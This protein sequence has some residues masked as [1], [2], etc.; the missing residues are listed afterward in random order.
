MREDPPHRRGELL[1]RL[2]AGR[3]RRGSSLLTSSSSRGARGRAPPSRA[4]GRL[5]EGAGCASRLGRSARRSGSGSEPAISAPAATRAGSVRG[6]ASTVAGLVAPRLLA[7]ASS[8]AVERREERVGLDV[9]LGLHVRR[10]TAGPP[11]TE[12]VIGVGLGPVS[13]SA[14][15]TSASGS[16]VA[17][18]RR[19]RIRSSS[20]A[21]SASS[22][23]GP[24]RAVARPRYGVGRAGRRRRTG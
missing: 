14:G 4:T 24:R 6:S 3:G 20:I 16:T 2:G 23:V 11:S 10:P 22:V 8:S 18:R 13:P 9:G 19:S 21:P 12:S 17:R 15:S 1:R 7:R 5:G